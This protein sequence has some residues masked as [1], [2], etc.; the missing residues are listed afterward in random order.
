M[1]VLESLWFANS[2]GTVGIVIGEDE[3]TKKRKAYIGVAEG[4]TE[5]LDINSISQLGSPLSLECVKNI[6]ALM[7]NNP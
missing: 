4:I 1:K 6:H 2:T 3:M 5:E 7:T